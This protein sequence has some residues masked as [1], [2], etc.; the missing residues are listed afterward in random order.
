[1]RLSHWLMVWLANDSMDTIR[2]HWLR[3]AS[4]LGGPLTARFSDG[5]ISGVFEG[6]DG[7]GYLQLRLISGELRQISAAD[8]FLGNLKD[9]RA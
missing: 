2:S 5:E 1:E 8:I 7:E 6:L 4:G 3:N 9:A